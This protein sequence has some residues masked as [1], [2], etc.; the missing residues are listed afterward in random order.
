MNNIDI[1]P[2]ILNKINLIFKNVFN[3]VFDLDYR[4]D[5]YLLTKIEEKRNKISNLLTQKCLF[6]SFCSNSKKVTIKN[7]SGVALVLC[8][9]EL[10]NHIGT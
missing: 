7:P 5:K 1:N 8:V 3:E 9:A 2:E 4:V 10:L 6:L